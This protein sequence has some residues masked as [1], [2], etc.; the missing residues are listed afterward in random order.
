MT[1]R[2]VARTIGIADVVWCAEFM[3]PDATA[4][5]AVS[6]SATW[7]V[8]EYGDDSIYA[9]ATVG[10]YY[11][12]SPCG[13]FSPSFSHEYSSKI[14]MTCGI[15]HV[16]VEEFSSAPGGGGGVG[17]GTSLHVTAEVTCDVVFTMMIY[18]P[19]LP[20]MILEEYA[21]EQ[22]L[23]NQCSISVKISGFRSTGNNLNFLTEPP[24]CNSG[25]DLGIDTCPNFWYHKVE[26]KG[27]VSDDAS[28]WAAKQS[29]SMR[30]HRQL[31]TDPVTDSGVVNE[32]DDDPEPEFLQKPA[33]QTQVYWVDGP[34]HSRNGVTGLYMIQNFTSKL[35]KGNRSC[36]VNWHAMLGVDGAEL[37]SHDLGPDHLSLEF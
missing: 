1:V 35:Q 30:Y 4:Q 11:G 3:P 19:A 13:Y 36:S 34:G 2:T 10:D 8:D 25:I 9:E 6:Y 37:V 33:G 28:L 26:I 17:A 24:L 15:D 31:G 14:E 12:S 27:T 29:M 18:C 23:V 32:P 16:E 21:G 20:G 5:C 22:V 7:V